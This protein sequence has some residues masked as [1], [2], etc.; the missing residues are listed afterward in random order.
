MTHNALT[1]ILNVCAGEGET[2]QTLLREI[3]DDIRGNLHLRFADFDTIHFARF[4][5]MDDNK[6]LLFSTTHDGPVDAHLAEFVTKA[7]SALDEIFG[8]CEG[9]PKVS[10]DQFNHAF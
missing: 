9:Y 5:M 1:V 6:R 7:R 2:L 4:V 8:K 3:G 10:D